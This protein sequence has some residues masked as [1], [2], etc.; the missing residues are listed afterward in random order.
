MKKAN[1]YMMK[2][3]QIAEENDFEDALAML[4]DNYGVLKEMGSQLDS[5]TYYYEKSLNYKLRL[6]DTVGIPFSLN[7]LAGA[8]A[9]KGNFEKALQYL[10]SSDIYRN[11]E[12]GYYGRAENLVLR[13]EVFQM[14]GKIDSSLFAF[15]SCLELA[16]RLNNT[17][18]IQYC[19]EQ[20]SNLYEQ[21]MNYRKALENFKNHIA[22]K[23]TMLNIE[24]NKRIAELQTA[25]ETEKKDR[26]I[27][28]KALEIKEKNSLL[29]ILVGIAILLIV[30]SVWIY[31]SQKQKRERIK[32]ELELKNKL[33]KATLE[34]N[35]RSEM[36]RISREL[37]DN[38]GSQLTFMISSLDNMT[39]NLKD[40]K[41]TDKLNSLK[42]FGRDTLTDLR[43]TVWAIKQEEGDINRLIMKINEMIQRLNNEMDTIKIKMINNIKANVNLSSSKMLNIY[44]IVQ[45]AIQNTMK[46]TDASEIVIEFKETGN[47][48]SLSIEDNGKGIDK[49]GLSGGSGI[50]NMKSRC[51]ESNGI[52]EIVG[53]N[54]GTR[55]LCMFAIN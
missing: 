35:I 53:D 7:K 8:Y 9:L 3:I 6:A 28:D 54:S 40:Y 44:R 34:N 48:F 42:N 29:M 13:G 33:T 26:L 49:E 17:N 24:T 39:Y 31:R 32:N 30:I 47:G 51:E 11:K 20:I 15:A 4:Y 27:L 23:D 12:K 55:I 18:L 36:L 43:N 52:F 46:H 41:I 16:K 21:K 2:G 50:Q 1:E 38:I 25:Y 10:N 19:Y 14:Q 5:A 45:E 37:H 22:F